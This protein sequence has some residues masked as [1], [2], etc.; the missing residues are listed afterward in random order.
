MQNLRI[1]YVTAIIVQNI[2]K[3][4]S[5]SPSITI[6]SYVLVI[7]IVFLII[8][9]VICKYAPILAATKTEQEFIKYK[10]QYPNIFVIK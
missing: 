3:K 9:S 5:L 2:A 8:L 1:Q 10:I 4:M 6:T 7:I